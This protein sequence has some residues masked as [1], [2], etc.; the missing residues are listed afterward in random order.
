M[1][2]TKLQMTRFHKAEQMIFELF[3]EL[4]SRALTEF[5]IHAFKVSLLSPDWNFIPSPVM[6]F[7]IVAAS[8]CFVR[9]SASISLVGFLPSVTLLSVTIAC[10]QRNTVTMCFT[11][12]SPRR[13]PIEIPAVVSI[14][15]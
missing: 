5:R 8:T 6:Q 14:H 3:T 13:L 9:K 15:R 4:L 1:G 10:A 7:S 11:R 12:P 2:F